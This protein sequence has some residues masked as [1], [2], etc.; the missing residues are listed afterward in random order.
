MVAQSGTVRYRKE[1]Y[2]AEPSKKQATIKEQFR[3]CLPIRGIRGRH[4]AVTVL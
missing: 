2:R 4:F 1:K 3:G